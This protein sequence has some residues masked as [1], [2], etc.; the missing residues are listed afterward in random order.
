MAIRLQEG[1]GKLNHAH[2]DFFLKGNLALEKTERHKPHAWLPDQG[3]EDMQRLETLPS[4]AADEEFALAKLVESVEQH[5]TAWQEYYDSEAPEE[6]PVP[7]FQG[8]I[9]SFEKL[10]VLRCLRMDRVTLAVQRFVSDYMGDKYITPPVADYRNIFRQSAPTTPVVFVLSPG[11]DPSF[12][13]IKLGE[14]MGFKLGAKLKSMALGQ[15]MG[16]KAKEYIELGAQRGLWVL[17]QNC[18]LLP[19]WLRELEKILEKIIEPHPDFRL[20]LTTEPT[21][22]FPLGILQ[23]SL[24]IVTEPPNGLKLNMRASYSKITDEMLAECPHDS[25]KSLVYVLAFFHAVVQER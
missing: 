17:L 6:L 9:N 7:F 1:E 24:K 18:H 22:A 2:L 16:P 11:A 3:W 15:G 25:F 13:L 21:D 4:A 19:S 12:D 10:L 23:R 14:D 8:K 20:W 5:G